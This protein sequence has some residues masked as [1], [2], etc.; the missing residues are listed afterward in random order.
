[1]GKMD[2]SEKKKG[3]GKVREQQV[4]WWPLL[5]LAPECRLEVHEQLKQLLSC[6]EWRTILR[7]T[8]S[9]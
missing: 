1:M 7:A 3:G 2:H 9:R 5:A 4:A 8:S 6:S